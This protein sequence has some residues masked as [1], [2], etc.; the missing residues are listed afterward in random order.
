MVSGLGGV[1][2][3][4]DSKLY[5]VTADSNNSITDKKSSLALCFLQ[6]FITLQH[7][8]TFPGS[9]NGKAVGWNQR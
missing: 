9:W 7:A 5:L 2:C 1:L 3:V 6:T 8:K 4:S